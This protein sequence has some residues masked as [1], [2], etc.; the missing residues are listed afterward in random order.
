MDPGSEMVAAGGVV[1]VFVAGFLLNR[2]LA[3]RGPRRAALV[4]M[5][6]LGRYASHRGHVVGEVVAETPEGLVLRQDGV[7]KLVPKARATVRDGEVVL[8]GDI[9][10]PAAEEAGKAWAPGG[11]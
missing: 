8:E 2:M 10:W 1:A 7:H 9:D 4:P 3:A 5:S 11:P 6:P